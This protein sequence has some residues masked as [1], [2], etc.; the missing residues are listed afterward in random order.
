MATTTNPASA[1]TSSPDAVSQ[2]TAFDPNQIHTRTASQQAATESPTSSSG[3][4][5]WK[6]QVIA[7]AKKTRGTIF[8]KPT[9]KEHGDQI[10]AGEASAREPTRKA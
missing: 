8:R 2:S 1:V 10:L 3:R 7:F 9:L 4:V 6:D 5:A